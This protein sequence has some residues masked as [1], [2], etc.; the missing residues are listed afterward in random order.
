MKRSTNANLGDLDIARL[1]I[2]PSPCVQDN[3]R[4]RERRLERERES[5]RDNDER[6]REQKKWSFS[7]T[8]RIAHHAR[9]R[10]RERERYNEIERESTRRGNGHFYLLRALDNARERERGKVFVHFAPIILRAKVMT[11]SADI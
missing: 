7:P 9:E 4:E 1:L 8:M 6:E 2:Q 10:V 11:G 5:K 3:E